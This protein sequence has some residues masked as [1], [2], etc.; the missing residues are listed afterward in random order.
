[1]LILYQKY[2]MELKEKFKEITLFHLSQ[3]KDQFTDSL[4]TLASMTK[5]DYGIEV[6]PLGIEPRD[7]LAYCLNVE[8][9]LDGKPWYY[10]IK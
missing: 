9:E 6:Q 4:T 5:I 2:L 3:D 1:M 7:S 8:V 10:N